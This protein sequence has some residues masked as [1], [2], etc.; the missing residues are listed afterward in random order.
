MSFSYE[1][2]LLCSQNWDRKQRTYVLSSSAAIYRETLVIKEPPSLT[3]LVSGSVIQF[4][5]SAVNRPLGVLSTPASALL[6]HIILGFTCPKS[7]CFS[8]AVA[9]LTSSSPLPTQTAFFAV[10]Q[11]AGFAGIQDSKTGPPVL[12]RDK[13]IPRPVSMHVRM[14]SSA[15]S[16]L[17]RSPQ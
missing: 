8:L 4:H 10:E 11:L 12:E 1:S 9:T 13:R 6:D 15:G 16:S 14:K 7:N 5:F 3:L 17:V 2:V